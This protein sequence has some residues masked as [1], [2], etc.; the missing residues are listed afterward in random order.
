MLVFALAD[1]APNARGRSHRNSVVRVTADETD[2]LNALRNRIDVKRQNTRS[3]LEVAERADRVFM[4]LRLLSFGTFF[5]FFG[6]AAITQSEAVAMGI[7]PS[8]AAFFVVLK[9][10]QPRRAKLREQWAQAV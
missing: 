5:G 9:V 1:C 7:I 2:R 3:D 10:H 8:L 6:F 4:G